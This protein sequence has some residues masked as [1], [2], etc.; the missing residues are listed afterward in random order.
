MA[1]SATAATPPATG[2]ASVAKPAS[3]AAPDGAQEFLSYMKQTP[4]QRMQDNWLR[5][6]GI[7]KAQFDA[8]TPAQQKALI[9]QMKQEIEDKMK[10]AAQSAPNGKTTL[11]V[12]IY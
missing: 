7:T 4:A 11:P 5:Q 10:Q 9:D 8:M 2:A 6:H 12:S 3:A 1:I